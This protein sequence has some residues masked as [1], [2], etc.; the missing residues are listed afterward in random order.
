M[1]KIFG[2][3]TAFFLG[4]IFYILITNNNIVEPG[5]FVGLNLLVIFIGYFIGTK[6][7][8]KIQNKEMAVIKTNENTKSGLVFYRVLF[9]ILGAIITPFLILYITKGLAFFTPIP[10]IFGVIGYFIGA[11]IGSYL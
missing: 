2:F 5:F 8:D 7:Y 11:K 10:I 6:I 3:L 4:A 9:G 1:K